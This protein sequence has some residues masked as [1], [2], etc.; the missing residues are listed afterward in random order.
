MKNAKAI[1]VAMFVLL[2]AQIASA[3]YCPS[4]GRWPNRD[5][6]GELGFELLRGGKPLRQNDPN[7]YSYVYNSPVFGIDPDGL[8]LWTKVKN[9]CWCKAKENTKDYLTDKMKEWLVDH[10]GPDAVEKAKK[11]CDIVNCPGESSDARWEGACLTCSLYK[12]A[13]SSVTGAGADM[14]M[15]QKLTGCLAGVAP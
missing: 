6:K 12:C 7:P 11:D 10:L 9:F 1:I 3:Y 15:K 4:T 14:C 8:S 5:P 13:L 2:T